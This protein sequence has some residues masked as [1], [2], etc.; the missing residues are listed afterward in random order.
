M[1]NEN[2]INSECH[3]NVIAF[4]LWGNNPKYTIGM[5]KN[6]ELAKD[7][8]PNWTCVIHVGS[9]VS[10]DIVK[11]LITHHNVIIK[12]HTSPGDWTSMFWRFYEADDK[13]VIMLSR[14][15]D[16]RLSTRERDA[17]GA[18]LAGDKDFHV[19]RDHREHGTDILG[20]M[21]GCR[22]GIMVGM[23]DWIAKYKGISNVWQTDQI[24]LKQIIS[25]KIQHRVCVHDEFF[26]KI[27][28]P[29][30]RVNGDYVGAPYDENNKRLIEL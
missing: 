29:T 27:S 25:P 7:L 30:P 12:Q 3:K 15:A 1:K 21:W 28:F 8:Y 18:W 17:V 11:N 5:I 26:A 10:E 6:V 19:M 22:N 14:D 16:S 4:S 2:L 13:D 24:F 9:S 20:G 23:R